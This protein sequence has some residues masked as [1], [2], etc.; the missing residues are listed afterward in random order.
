MIICIH[1]CGFVLKPDQECLVCGRFFGLTEIEEHLKE[2]E[3]IQDK[4]M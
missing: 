3:T 1:V 4:K 2:C